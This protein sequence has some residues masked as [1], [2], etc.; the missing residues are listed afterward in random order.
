VR[1][2]IVQVLI[3]VDQLINA[4]LGGWSDE[5]L[6]SRV[7]RCEMRGK[8]V[9]KVGRPVIDFVL[10]PMEPNHCARAYQAERLRAQ[11]P[12]EFREDEP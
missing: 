7:W 5:S 9:G 4:I 2:W 8:P 1:F 10:R 11:L 12:P 6:S 3:A